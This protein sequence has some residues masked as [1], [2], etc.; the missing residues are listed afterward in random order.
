MARRTCAP[1]KRSGCHVL[2]VL[3]HGKAVRLVKLHLRGHRSATER[4]REGATDHCDQSIGFHLNVFHLQ[5]IIRATANLGGN[6]TAL[7]NQLPDRRLVSI[8][9]QGICEVLAQI[10][11]GTQNEQREGEG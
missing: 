4:P 7:S 2:Q 8:I 10:S 3:A 6:A 11:R 5:G 1:G 9:D